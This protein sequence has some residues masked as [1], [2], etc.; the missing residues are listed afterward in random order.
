MES[1]ARSTTRRRLSPNSPGLVSQF[2]DLT[3]TKFFDRKVKCWDKGKKIGQTVRLGPKNNNS[4]RP[5][6][7]PL[8]FRQT[9]VDCDQGVEAPGHGI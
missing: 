9:L 8:L 4:E 3:W 5:L 1:I 6:V 2:A 7:K